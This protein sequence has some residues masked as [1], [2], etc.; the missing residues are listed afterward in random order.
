MQSEFINE[1]ISHTTETGA[2]QTEKENIQV[3]SSTSFFCFTS[4]LGIVGTC[5]NSTASTFKAEES[6]SNIILSSNSMCSSVKIKG[7]AQRPLGSWVSSG[8]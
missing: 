6:D 3:F 7:G 5:G 8:Q 1:S 2:K 4:R